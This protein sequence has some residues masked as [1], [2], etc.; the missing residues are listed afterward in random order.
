MPALARQTL[1]S[2]LTELGIVETSRVDDVTITSSHD[3]LT[4][5]SVTIPKL[6]GERE[7]VPSTLFYDNKNVCFRYVAYFHPLWLQK[8]YK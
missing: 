4:I 5:G 6:K 2:T 1:T 7:L 8:T 3:T